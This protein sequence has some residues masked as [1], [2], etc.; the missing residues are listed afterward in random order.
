V[1][2]T[3]E[4]REM[5]ARP[6]AGMTTEKYIAKQ[7]TSAIEHWIMVDRRTRMHVVEGA[8]WLYIYKWELWRRDIKPLLEAFELERP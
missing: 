3:P 8:D 6:I 5:L 7:P 1:E 2:L 4:H